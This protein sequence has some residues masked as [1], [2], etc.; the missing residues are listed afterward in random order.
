[1]CQKGNVRTTRG[2]NPKAKKKKQKFYKKCHETHRS[3]ANNTMKRNNNRN[4][5]IC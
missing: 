4:L 1:M 5:Y 3:H 2:K